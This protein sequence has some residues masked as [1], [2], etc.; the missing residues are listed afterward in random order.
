MRRLVLIFMMF[1]LP[2]QWSWAAA[3]SV[4]EHEGDTTHFGH[5]EHKHSGAAE[6]MHQVSSGTWDEGGAEGGE[7]TVNYHPDCHACH[8]IGTACL[9]SISVDAQAWAGEG[10]LPA[11]GRFIPEPPIQTFL[12]PPLNLVA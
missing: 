6:S 12:R 1:L 8:G 9:A 5:H 2:L 3:A 11:Y 7:G 10:P 4:C